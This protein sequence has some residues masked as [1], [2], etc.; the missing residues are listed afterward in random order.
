MTSPSEDNPFPQVWTLVDDHVSFPLAR[1]RFS[2]RTVGWLEPKRVTQEITSVYLKN[3]VNIKYETGQE[4]RNSEY[5]PY[6]RR[7]FRSD[8]SD[9]P[10]PWG[11][12]D[13][14][15]RENMTRVNWFLRKRLMW[16]VTKSNLLY[17]VSRVLRY[18]IFSCPWVWTEDLNTT[19]HLSKKDGFYQNYT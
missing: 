3:N 14:N 19:I 11:F 4:Y 10:S 5:S 7:P 9:Q 6:W 18:R 17:R 16:H 8:S 15:G 1:R 13:H 12:G 2:W